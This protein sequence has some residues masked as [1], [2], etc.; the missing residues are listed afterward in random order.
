MKNLT[1]LDVNKMI[2]HINWALKDASEES[3]RFAYIA[4]KIEE[5][6]KMRTA[7]KRFA[8]IL[9]KQEEKSC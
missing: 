6:K 9:K 4:M 5:V 3:Y 1:R 7:L 8:E 2:K